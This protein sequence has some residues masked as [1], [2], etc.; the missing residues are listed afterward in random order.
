MTNRCDHE[1]CAVREQVLRYITTYVSLAGERSINAG[2]IFSGIAQLPVCA[3]LLTWNL[4]TA[5]LEQFKSEGLLYYSPEP[6]SARKSPTDNSQQKG[7]ASANS[8]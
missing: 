5:I 4:F 3:D 1:R 2:N 7:E 8:N 6:R